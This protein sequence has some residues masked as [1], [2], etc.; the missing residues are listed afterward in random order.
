MKKGE[1]LF[2]APPRAEFERSGVKNVRFVD[3][4]IM[5]Q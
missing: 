5:R 4:D 2:W 3:A 1:T